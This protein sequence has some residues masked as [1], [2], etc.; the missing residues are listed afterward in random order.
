MTFHD[1]N[2]NRAAAREEWRYTWNFGDDLTEFTTWTVWHYFRKPGRFNVSVTFE[3]LQGKK[4]LQ[5]DM[6]TPLEVKRTVSV[7]P[8]I[9]PFFGERTWIELIKL[10][11]ALFVAGIGLIAGARDQLLKLDPVPGLIAVFIAGF[12]ADTIKNLIKK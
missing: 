8:E 11:I 10:A 1:D 9:I 2:L 5:A 7:D 4:V 3:D 12:G 6:M